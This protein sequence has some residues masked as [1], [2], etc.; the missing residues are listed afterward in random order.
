MQRTPEEIDRRIDE[1]RKKL[2]EIELETVT[3][4]KSVKNYSDTPLLSHL[5]LLYS[6]HKAML[7]ELEWCN[8]KNDFNEYRNETI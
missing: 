5:H 2:N 6:T 4:L 3:A 7:N 1:T 8:G